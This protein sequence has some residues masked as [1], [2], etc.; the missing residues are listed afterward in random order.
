MALEY[1]SA[2]DLEVV[3]GQALRRRT[4]FLAGSDQERLDDLHRAFADPAIDG[5][6]CVR[7]G[8]GCTR[9][10]GALDIGLVRKNPKVFIGYSDITALHIA[11]AQKAGVM[12]FHG[13]VAI[14]TPSDFAHRA[15]RRVLFEGLQPEWTRMEAVR[16]GPMRGKL[17]GGNLSILAALAGTP[18]APDFN[19]RVVVIED[20]GERPYRL[21]R[22]LTQ[23]LDGTN[24]R[25][26]SGILVGDFTDCEPPPEE[27]GTQSSRDVLEERLGQ[28]GIPV[29]TGLPI[30]HIP[31]QVTW[32]YGMDYQFSPG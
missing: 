26:A 23:L 21:D 27:R 4:G 19:G 12:T 10:L 2:L 11:I 9:L 24:L 28:L 30:G 16:P 17:T 13:P 14:E 29:Y 32:G 1:L 22:M 18:W 15:L 6:W 20:I 5:I 3:E 31:E 8:Y 7:G 25:K